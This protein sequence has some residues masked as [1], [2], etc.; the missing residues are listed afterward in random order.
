MFEN[1]AHPYVA[2]SAQSFFQ[3]TTV[4]SGMQVTNRFVA[5]GVPMEKR[6]HLRWLF[7]SFVYWVLG[8][9]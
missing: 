1:E 7:D 6:T 9:P 4:L 3:R 2:M 5:S 8:P